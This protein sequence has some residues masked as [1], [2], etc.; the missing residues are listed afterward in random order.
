MVYSEKKTRNITYYICLGV[1][2]FVFTWY[3]ILYKVTITINLIAIKFTKKHKDQ[4]QQIRNNIY[5]CSNKNK[6]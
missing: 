6:Q 3:E 5:I 2:Y 1:Q 4:S